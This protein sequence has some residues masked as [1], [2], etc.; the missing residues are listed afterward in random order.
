MID[1]AFLEVWYDGCRGRDA[2]P[3]TPSSAH[4]DCALEIACCV[5]Y[6]LPL[7]HKLYEASRVW[8]MGHQLTSA[9]F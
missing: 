9:Y 3:W 5:Q 2:M 6:L 4:L 1:D 7:N 8:C